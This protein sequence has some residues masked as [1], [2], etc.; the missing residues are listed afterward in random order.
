MKLPNLSLILLLT[1]PISLAIASPASAALFCEGVTSN[2]GVCEALVIGPGFTYEWTATGSAYLTSPAP[3]TASLRTV[4]C[5][6]NTRQAGSIR[7]RIIVPGGGSVFRSRTICS[8]P[9]EDDPF[10]FPF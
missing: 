3:P 7:V 6:P 5:F 9:P 1:L 2:G 8:L 10:I 4:A